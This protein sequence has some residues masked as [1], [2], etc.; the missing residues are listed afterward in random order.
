MLFVN[1]TYNFVLV[2]ELMRFGMI[3]GIAFA[4]SLLLSIIA[5][6]VKSNKVGVEGMN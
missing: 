6:P 1:K 4:S 5:R 2:T 3:I